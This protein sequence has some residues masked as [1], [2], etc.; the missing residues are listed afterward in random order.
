[1]N[2]LVCLCTMF[3][4]PHYIRHS[5][6]VVLFLQNLLIAQ[7]GGAPF[8]IIIQLIGMIFGIIDLFNSKISK[9]CCLLFWVLLRLLLNFVIAF[10]SKFMY[11]SLTNF[12]P[13]CVSIPKL[14]SYKLTEY[15][16][17][18]FSQFKLVIVAKG[19]W[20]YRHCL[21]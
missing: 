3:C 12:W 10:R 15:V 19:Y 17:T 13:A 6:H 16:M 2:E 4:L 18:N 14:Y 7:R 11:I 8:K 1:M 20:I 5:N 21:Y 9:G